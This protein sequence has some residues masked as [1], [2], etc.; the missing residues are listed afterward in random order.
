MVKIF[1]CLLFLTIEILGFSKSL[2]AQPVV[3][4]VQS[5]QVPDEIYI[6][7]MCQLYTLKGSMLQ[8]FYVSGKPCCHYDSR[9]Y[10][11]PS[12]VSVDQSMKTMLFFQDYQTMVICNDV[13]GEIRTLFLS[14]SSIPYVSLANWSRDQ[15]IWLLD[16]SSMR[17]LKLNEA[18]QILFQTEP[19]HLMLSQKWSPTY[20]RE[21]ENRIFITDPEKG[22]LILDLYG[23]TPQVIPERG[24]TGMDIYDKQIVYQ[25]GDELRAYDFQIKQV[26][27]V[28]NIQVGGAKR[29]KVCNGTVFILTEQGVEKKTLNKQ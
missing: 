16:P 27:K 2:F 4:A 20:M 19:I 3:P 22:I 9:R 24:V 1:L 6:D 21:W 7:P 13:L 12:L 25:K 5:K 23:Y 10:G 28:E 15:H 26:K 17:I 8:K 11:V 14:E 18:G 29:T